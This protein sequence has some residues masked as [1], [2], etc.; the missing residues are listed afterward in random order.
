MK[1]ISSSW[2]V[3]LFALAVM[4][5][6]SVSVDQVTKN[7]AERK[8]RVWS[9]PHDLKMYQGQRYHLWTIGDEYKQNDGGSLA[10]LSFNFNYVRN[11]GAAWGTF[12]DWDDRI[13]VPFFY[14][15]TVFAICVIIYY[16]RQTLSFID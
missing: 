13:R 5:L 9:D 10:F 6:G 14:F 1:N 11:Q 8:L 16:F 15:V 12:S 2:R 7:L 4:I 3:S